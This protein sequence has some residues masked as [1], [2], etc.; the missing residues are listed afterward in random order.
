MATRPSPAFSIVVRINVPRQPGLLPKIL[1]AAEQAGGYVESIRACG[2]PADLEVRE[3]TVATG[4]CEHEAAVLLA[5]ARVDGV[6][7]LDVTERTFAEHMGG[8]IG[9]LERATVDG[10]DALSRVY[11][12]GVGRVSQAIAEDN[13]QQWE[14]TIK[15]NTVAVVSDGTAVLGLGDVGPAAAQPVMEG[16]CLLFKHFADVD[17]FPICLATTDVDEIVATVQRIAPVFG[18][19]NLEDIA[20]P[21]CFAIEEQLRERLDI[22][23]MHD[24]QHATAIVVLAALRNAL[25][26]VDKALEDAKIVISGAG[27][28]GLATARILLAAGARRIVSCD[29]AG[30]IYQG[31]PERMN[32]Y[33]EALAARSNP[34][35]ERGDLQDVVAGADV[36]IG[37]S[38]PR[39][40]S[41]AAVASMAANPIVFA[42]ANP[43]PEVLPDEIEGI[44]RVVATGRS[45]Y[46]NQ[47]NNSLAFPGVFR[48]AL[49]VRASEINFEMKI[50]ASEALAGL[51]SEADLQR[52]TI[53]P[54]MFD[55]RVVPAVAAAVREA[56]CRTGVAR[57]TWPPAAKLAT[58]LTT[59]AILAG[60]TLRH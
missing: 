26:L 30:A 23:V 6:R 8:M 50:A 22:P 46:P 42:M 51:V 20:A 19:I 24:D 33:K 36:F 60:L 52:E 21:R 56:A 7:L 40:L 37:L 25:R 31:R 1:E 16:K 27:A 13:T 17:A 55:P 28:A 44:A 3:L 14:L 53:V 12:P 18:A 29:R 11:T 38:A 54:S 2:T 41:R 32:S 57:R 59:S 45:D 58:P 43:V 9:T 15:P 10:V 5:L 47:I 4:D 34:D 48:A 35:R 39:L 49:D